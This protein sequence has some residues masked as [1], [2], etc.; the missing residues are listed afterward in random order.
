MTDF[1][2]LPWYGWWGAG[3][4]TYTRRAFLSD[5]RYTL[6]EGD[7]PANERVLGTFDFNFVENQR[8][9]NLTLRE[10][11]DSESN[12]VSPFSEP[13]RT[14]DVEIL[15][16]VFKRSYRMSEIAADTKNS[17]VLRRKVRGNDEVG[18]VADHP[19]I[20]LHRSFTVDAPSMAM[21]IKA[22]VGTVFTFYRP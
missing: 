8:R 1:S 5:I 20:L 13:L 18:W 3:Q 4:H 17:S 16:N 12:F 7:D 11:W 22:L 9:P 10:F 21:P 6:L 2:R 14:I 19:G 15:G